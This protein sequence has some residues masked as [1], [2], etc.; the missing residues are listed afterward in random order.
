MEEKKKK[1]DCMTVRVTYKRA[2]LLQKDVSEIDTH[3]DRDLI[4]IQNGNFTFICSHR[5]LPKPHTNYPPHLH[6]ASVEGSSLFPFLPIIIIIAEKEKKMGSLWKNNF[7]QG[8]KKKK[9][10]HDRPCHIHTCSPLANEDENV[11]TINAFQF[12]CT[13]NEINKE[14]F[15]FLWLP[16]RTHGKEPR[17]DIQKEKCSGG[18]ETINTRTRSRA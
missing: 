5:K 17:I 15:S 6:T 18:P 4:N 1:E 2:H 11:C 7:M 3:F 14:L 13:K 16:I 10:L 9:R 12:T 8:K